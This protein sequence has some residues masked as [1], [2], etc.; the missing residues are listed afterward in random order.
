MSGKPNPERDKRV[1]LPLEP[2][3]VLRALLA[4]KPDDKPADQQPGH[5]DGQEDAPGVAGRSE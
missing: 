5:G 3:T 1:E 4:V 2:E